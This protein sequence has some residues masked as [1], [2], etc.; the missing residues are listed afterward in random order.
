MYFSFFYIKALFI[1]EQRFLF[2]ND[3]DYL[4]EINSQ[5]HYKSCNIK[6]I[7]IKFRNNANLHT[8]TTV[9]YI[10]TIVLKIWAGKV[11]ENKI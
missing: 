1:L 11:E 8:I 3:K 10:L 4:L 9:P 6:D 5:H 7:L 2:L